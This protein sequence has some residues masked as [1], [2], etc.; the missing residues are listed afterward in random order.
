TRFDQYDS[1]P[2]LARIVA[3]GAGTIRIAGVELKLV[4][5]ICGENNLLQSSKRTSVLK[6]PPSDE[7]HRSQLSSALSGP[8]VVLNPA[9]NPYYP[10]ALP[11][12]FAKVGTVAMA[13]RSAGPT[14][15]WLVESRTR[16]RD[17]TE[18]P[19]AVI[20]V[21]N[22]FADRTATVPFASVGFGDSAGR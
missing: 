7:E 10:Q 16:F 4:L 9:H 18:S 1:F 20:H 8:W 2:L 13:G 17:G 12:G 19:V 5:F 22:F 21:S 6:A 11:K 14:L 3:S 15:R